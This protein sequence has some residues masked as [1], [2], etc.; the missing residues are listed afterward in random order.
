MLRSSLDPEAKAVSRI[1][2]HREFASRGAAL[3]N[4]LI[5][6][7]GTQL[8]AAAREAIILSK[9]SNNGVEQLIAY[10]LEKDIM[11]QL[12]AFASGAGQVA[13]EMA[14]AL[15]FVKSASASSPSDT[16]WLGYCHRFEQAYPEF[17]I[18]FISQMLFHK[19]IEASG[20]I[21]DEVATR[22][23][24]DRYEARVRCPT[25]IRDLP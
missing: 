17:D 12:L 6:I 13:A 25:S 1:Q 20:N 9:V 18:P 5:L 22:R 23:Y 3:G 4:H 7:E 11:L 16:E 24:V 14:F 2:Q 10:T 19:A 21:H 8:L 15:Q